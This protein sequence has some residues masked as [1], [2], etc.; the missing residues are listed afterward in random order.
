[1]T[2]RPPLASALRRA[3]RRRRRPRKGKP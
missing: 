1:M 2:P 3:P